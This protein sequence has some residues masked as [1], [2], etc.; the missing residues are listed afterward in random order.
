VPLLLGLGVTELSAS[1]PVVPAIKAK[2]RSLRLSECTSLAQTA[3]R[4]ASAA[5]VRALL[6]S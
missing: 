1:G 3:M 6:R 2:V 4:A 5:D